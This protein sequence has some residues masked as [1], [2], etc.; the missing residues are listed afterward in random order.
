MR[1]YTK[2]GDLPFRRSAFPDGQPHFTLL[3]VDEYRECTV[4][5]DICSPEDLFALTLAASVLGQNGYSVNLDIR[6]LMGARM[7]RAIDRNQPFT[8]DVVTRVIN[9]TGFKKVRVLDCHSPVGLGLLGA[10]NVLPYDIVRQVLGRFGSELRVI[11]P[12]KGAWNRVHSLTADWQLQYQVP[13]VQCSK[14]REMAT[15][16]LT[17]FKVED[18]S[19][20]K[21]HPCLIIDDI[22]DGGGTFIGLAKELRAVGATS[23]KLFVTHSIFS[24]G[25]KLEGID[26]IFTTDSY[27]T[28]KGDSIVFKVNMEEMK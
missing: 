26:Q 3:H 24:R 7:D 19:F 14:T 5:S 6:Y 2:K 18:P 22:C 23:V 4:E 16:N 28:V 21:G 12:D 10:T 9:C 13:L 27:P 11:V 15:G 8:L 1:I 25:P 17:N 20:V